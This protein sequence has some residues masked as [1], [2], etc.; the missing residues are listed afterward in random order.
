MFTRFPNLIRTG[1]LGLTVGMT[2]SAGCESLRTLA[3]T[4]PA[5][6]T[7]APTP[8]TST[9][10]HKPGKHWL[11][12]SQYVFYSDA[13]LT[14]DDPLFRELEG[15]PEQIQRELK[16]PPSTQVIQVFLFN[17]QDAYESFMRERYPWLPVRRAYFIADQKRP[18]TQDDL[19]V[20]TWLGEHLR[21]D[22]RHE[23]T[24]AI[25]H[26]VL[27]G[28]PLWLDEGLA[29]FFEQPVGHDGVNPSHLD[30]LRKSTFTPDLARLEKLGQVK[31]MEKAEY[32]EAWA[33][34]HFCLRGN[35]GAKT[36]LLSYMARLREDADP[37]PLLPALQAA[38]PHPGPA[39]L[40]HL[41]RT[42]LPGPVARGHMADR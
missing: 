11:R 29:G 9:T 25:L 22:L 12:L 23:L 38:V 8:P 21:T 36:A 33:W 4:L 40:D 27:K 28:V 32:R 13:P 15:L 18:G 30:T 1:F 42:E 20:Y 24:H 17:S 19:V 35:P 10:V 14:A 37:G 39:L 34:V 26:G 16:L 5:G 7:P 6:T 2:A 41:A 31:Q 3:P